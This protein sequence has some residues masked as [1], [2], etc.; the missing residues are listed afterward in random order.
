[1]KYSKPSHTYSKRGER[2]E[3]AVLGFLLGVFVFLVVTAVVFT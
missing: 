1:M 3:Q 2:G